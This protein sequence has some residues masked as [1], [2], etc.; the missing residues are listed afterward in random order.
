MKIKLRFK[1]SVKTLASVRIG[2]NEIPQKRN[3]NF[4]V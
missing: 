2:E 1:K 4:S 3:L